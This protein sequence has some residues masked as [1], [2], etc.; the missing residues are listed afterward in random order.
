[1]KSYACCMGAFF[2]QVPTEDA[3]DRDVHLFLAFSLF[4]VAL[5]FS[6]CLSPD[7]S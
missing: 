5:T 7:F 3:E 2:L 6:V 1:M 4:Y